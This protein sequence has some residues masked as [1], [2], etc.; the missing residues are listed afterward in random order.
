[1]II[2]ILLMDIATAP[3]LRI[4]GLDNTNMTIH[5]MY[6]VTETLINLTNN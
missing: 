3:T 6:I 5:I 1:M 4:K 2:I